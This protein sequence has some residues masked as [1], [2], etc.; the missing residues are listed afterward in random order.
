MDR[1][2]EEQTDNHDFIG[3]SVG[4][5]LII[6]VTLSFPEFTSKHQKPVY[7]INFF[8]RYS[9]FRFLQPEWALPF[10]TIPIQIL[11]N[12]LLISMNLYQNAKNQA[13]SS[14]HSR[15][16]NYLKILQSDWPK[17]FRHIS[18]GTNFSEIFPSIQQLI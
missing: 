13:F 11:F 2:T 14:F 9:Q 18:Q 3:P 12:Q 5:G 1:Q 16:I 15:D 7:F 10:T 17:T 4:R 8:V 6:K